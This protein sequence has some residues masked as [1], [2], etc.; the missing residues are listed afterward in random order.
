MIMSFLLSLVV[1]L[2][3]YEVSNLSDYEGPGYEV[4]ESSL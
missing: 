2:L 3:E 1:H 4:S